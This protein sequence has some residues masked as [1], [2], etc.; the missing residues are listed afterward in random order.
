MSF[1]NPRLSG[2]EMLQMSV[3]KILIE[4]INLNYK[5]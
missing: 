4:C 1:K 3:Q 2:I 5:K